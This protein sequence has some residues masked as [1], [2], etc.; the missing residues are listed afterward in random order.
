MASVPLR[1]DWATEEGA[2]T[3][4]VHWNV[5]AEG[6]AV[7]A[8]EARDTWGSHANLRTALRQVQGP[9]R[10]AAVVAPLAEDGA[11]VV[12]ALVTVGVGEGQVLRGRGAFS[13]GLLRQSAQRLAGL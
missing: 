4:R 5:A 10:L 2:V 1:W 9:V 12:P 7:E 8:P 3:A 13:Y 11:G 6:E